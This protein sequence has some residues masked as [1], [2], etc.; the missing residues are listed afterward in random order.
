MSTQQRIFFQSWRKVRIGLREI[1]RSLTD[2]ELLTLLVIKDYMA[3]ENLYTIQKPI[4][5]FVISEH[6]DFSYQTFNRI[7][8]AL[9]K[10]RFLNP[11]KQ[12]GT[13]VK[14][15]AEEYHLTMSSRQLE[16]I[17]QND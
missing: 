2:K 10:K 16:R 7:F 4:G 1:G 6:F 5:F 13:A 11:L 9:V 14:F 17:G 12:K 3:A 15:K 8:N